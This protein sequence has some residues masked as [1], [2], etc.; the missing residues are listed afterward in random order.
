MPRESYNVR[1]LRLKALS[2]F[3]SGVGAF[4]ALDDEGR[5]T[6]VLLTLQ[7]AF[8]MLLKAA[9]EAKKVPVFD[10]RSGKSISLEHAIRK[11]QQVESIAMS[12]DESGTVRAL[13]SLRDAE[14]HWHVVVDEGLLYLYVRSAVTLFDDLLARV[15]SERLGDHLPT[16]VLPISAEPPEALELLVDRE[17]E[18]IARLLKPG[19]RATAEANARIRAL[20]AT[21]ALADPDAAEV[22]ETDVRRVARGIREGKA[23]TQVFP[24]LSGYSADVTGSG[25]TVEVRLVK[26]GG[27]PV[28]YTNGPEVNPSAIRTVDLEKKFYMGPYDLADRSGVTRGRATALRRHLA[29]D[30]N[31]DH[32]SHRFVFGNT[33]HL[34]YSDNALKAMRRA[35]VTVDLER[36]WALHRTLAYNSKGTLPSCTQPGCA[37]AQSG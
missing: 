28:T 13:D 33:K 7:H 17:Y 10:E 4:N 34:R 30:G 1:T 19:R 3:R 9:L 2:S 11:C 12:D 23:R 24:K 16:R 31:D 25:L 27:L 32:F 18:R 21:E 22:S 36:V 26:S 6:L 20:L 14:Q 37:T 29:L 15:F 8:E 35:L 5:T